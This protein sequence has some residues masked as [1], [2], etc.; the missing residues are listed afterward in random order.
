[1]S[2]IDPLEQLER[3]QRLKESGALD[4]DE[5]EREKQRILAGE[6]EVTASNKRRNIV[7]G[8]V[9][10]LAAIGVGILIARPMQQTVEQQDSAKGGAT[11]AVTVAA[12]EPSASAAPA[13]ELAP[14]T[15]LAAAFQAATGRAGPHATK[16]DGQPART[17]PLRVLDLPFGP[18]LLTATETEDA[19]HACAG[20][21]GVYYLKQDGA[22]F[23]VTGK[24]PEAVSGRGWGTAPK[25]WSISDRFTSFPA[26]MADGGFT[27]QGVV[28]TTLVLTELR[29]EG[30]VTSDFIPL[31]YS[32]AGNVDSE[33]GLTFSG[34][35]AIELQGKI[36][37]IVKDKSFEVQ[38]KGGEPFSERYVRRG[39]K[40]VR[41][42]ESSP[43]TC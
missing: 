2:A 9:L 39:G 13:I 5:F 16:L 22:R 18:V 6:P 32:N 43:L 3:L 17:A 41:V 38:V 37:N 1:M 31:S 11:S 7:I 30:P 20:A 23:T 14:A 34:G 33:T 26:I 21:L 40:F 35:P 36:V 8:G 15:K 29:P 42:S 28:C 4:A 27:G 25:D 10:A 12:I 24:W 19:C